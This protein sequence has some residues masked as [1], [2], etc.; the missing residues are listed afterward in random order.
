MFFYDL[1]NCLGVMATH[2][3]L[4]MPFGVHKILASFKPM[5]SW[6]VQIIAHIPVGAIACSTDS[7]HLYDL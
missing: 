2:V 4:V 5:T 7:I 6:E 3:C 1:Y